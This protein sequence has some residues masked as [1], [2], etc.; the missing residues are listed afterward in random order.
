M[1]YLSGIDF[2]W[3]SLGLLAVCSAIAILLLAFY[4]FLVRPLELAD[5]AKR[6]ETENK[7]LIAE[8]ESLKRDFAVL[9]RLVSPV[10]VAEEREFTVGGT[11]E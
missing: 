7:Q 10:E 9:H 5:K 11:E 3:E 4:Y 1:S 6:V 8:C 2:L